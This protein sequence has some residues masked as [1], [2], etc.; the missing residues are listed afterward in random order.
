MLRSDLIIPGGYE[1]LE[2]LQDV[3]DSPHNARHQDRAEKA[4]PLVIPSSS[5]NANYHDENVPPKPITTLTALNIERDRLSHL[6]QLEGR[7]SDDLNRSRH[8]FNPVSQSTYPRQA[9]TSLIPSD[10]KHAHAASRL[11]SQSATGTSAA[12]TGS[13]D[14][15]RKRSQARAFLI[16]MI[17]TNGG[18]LNSTD[19][20]NTTVRRTCAMVPT[21]SN[22]VVSH[23]FL[24]GAFQGLYRKTHY[25][26]S[27][28]HLARYTM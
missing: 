10:A 6:L 15:E 21:Y 17:G 26:Y 19:P 18:L 20:Y 11:Y 13:H 12:S 16:N 1:F 23:R 4:S 8:R 9:Y 14:K 28:N 7:E 25:G 27:L 5:I 22:I 24:L 3:A 2:S